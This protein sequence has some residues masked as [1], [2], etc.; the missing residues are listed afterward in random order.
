MFTPACV[1]HH[2]PFQ[3][4]DFSGCLS[5][6][7]LS[8]LRTSIDA[9]QFRSVSRESGS[10]KAYSFH[11]CTLVKD[12]RLV[13]NDLPEIWGTLL[14]E[15]CDYRYVD[16]MKSL[17]HLSMSDLDIDIE[18][19]RY[20]ESDWIGPHTDRPDRL[21]T[22]IF[23]LNEQWDKSDGGLL[24]LLAAPRTDAIAHTIVPVTPVSVAFARS[25]RSWHYVSP[26]KNDKERLSFRVDLKSRHL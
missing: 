24:H 3:W 25:T 1:V 16:I 10:D 22:H 7:A 15:I 19:F 12:G 26:V 23:Y 11:V 6:E 8:M 17:F 18:V 9:L 4:A 14:S 20:S 21:V 13:G 5:T 2:E